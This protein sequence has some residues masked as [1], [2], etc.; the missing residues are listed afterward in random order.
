MKASSINPVDP[1]VALPMVVK[2]LM[3][4]TAMMVLLNGCASWR[5]TVPPVT[6][7]QIVAWSQEG[8]PASEIIAKIRESGTVYRLEASQLADLRGKGVPDAVINYMQRTYLEAVRR[9]Q[10]LEDRNNWAFD[11]GYWYGGWPWGW[12]DA[13]SPY[14]YPYYPSYPDRDR[15]RNLDRDTDKNRDRH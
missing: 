5:E 3:L 11:G 2:R 15:E 9:N 10:F 8:V 12:P 1:P 4:I 14:Y 13:W 7:P 6:V